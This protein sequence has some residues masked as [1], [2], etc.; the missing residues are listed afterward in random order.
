M[1]NILS[2]FINKTKISLAASKEAE[3]E[4]KLQDEVETEDSKI[5]PVQHCDETLQIIEPI[6]LEG[7][8]YLICSKLI[9]F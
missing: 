8:I 3:L 5:V 1:Y 2:E 7:N 9:S 4:D 6:K